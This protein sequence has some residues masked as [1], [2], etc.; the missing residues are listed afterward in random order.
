MLKMA[1][2]HIVPSSGPKLSPGSPVPYRARILN[3][4]SSLLQD[5]LQFFYNVIIM[6]ANHT[7]T[8]EQK[9]PYSC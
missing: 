3:E 6:T 2:T 5:V 1:E 4:E 7:P 8:G 9:Q